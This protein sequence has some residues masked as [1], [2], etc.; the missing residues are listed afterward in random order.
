M[1]RVLLLA[2]LASACVNDT[3]SSLSSDE[4]A[5]AWEN[6]IA[7]YDDNQ[8][9]SVNLRMDLINTAPVENLGHVVITGLKYQ[10]SRA[11]GLPDP[12]TFDTFQRV[13][14]ELRRLIQME[15]K[16]MLVGTF[17][18]NRER[19][20]YFY[21]EEVKNLEQ[22]LTKFYESKYPAYEFSL[23]IEEDKEWTHYREFLYPNEETIGYMNDLKITQALMEAGDRSTEP[24]RIDHWLYFPSKQ[25]LDSCQVA[26]TEMGFS[27]EKAGINDAS[28]LKHELQVY[29]MDKADINTIYPITSQMRS[30]ANQYQGDYD[31]WETILVK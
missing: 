6:Y 28:D 19:L 10:T 8:P 11:D 4:A 23:K 24:R 14:E 12:P 16:A 31:G 17:T 13:E 30:L 29:R 3:D 27:V 7:S 20:E 22:Q 1:K 2:F 25:L 15:T 26:L 21:V 5:E 18:Y 9:G